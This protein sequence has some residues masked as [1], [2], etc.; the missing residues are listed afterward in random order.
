[1]P[2]MNYIFGG[3][4]TSGGT[5]LFGGFGSN[6]ENNLLTGP[7]SSGAIFVIP[8]YRLNVL[9]FLA[10]RELYEENPQMPTTGNYGFQDQRFA[11]QWVQKHIAAFNGDPNR[12]MVAGQSAG[13][14]LCVYQLIS[15]S[16]G[17][18]NL[19][20]GSHWLYSYP[21]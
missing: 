12:I 3:S 6:K 7:F 21:S 2:V 11:A 16:T 5:G 17:R 10:L 18:W 15:M 20:G 4:F 13:T 19:S 14:K 1:M 9:G 8:N